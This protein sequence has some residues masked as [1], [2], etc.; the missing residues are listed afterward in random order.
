MRYNIATRCACSISSPISPRCPCWR[1]LWASGLKTA[2]TPGVYEP[3][4]LLWKLPSPL[5]HLVFI[6]PPCPRYDGATLLPDTRRM[7]TRH[8]A[9]LHF[10]VHHPRLNLVATVAAT[11]NSSRGSNGKIFQGNCNK[12]AHVNLGLHFLINVMST[13]LLA[14]SNYG[15]QCLSAPT[16]SEVDKAHRRR[17]RLDIGVMGFRNTRWV[18]WGRGWAWFLLGIS[19]MPLHLL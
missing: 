9:W 17:A 16:R 1:S 10:R 7:A 19:S 13:L 4:S 3:R 12:A 15:M 11:A 2:E 5:G 14:A 6:P 18:H 8:P